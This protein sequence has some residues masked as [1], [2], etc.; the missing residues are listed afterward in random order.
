MIRLVA[1]QALSLSA[2]RS[3]WGPGRSGVHLARGMRFIQY[4]ATTSNDQADSPGISS[5]EVIF[6]YPNPPV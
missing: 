6:N 2:D 5:G 1:M 3:G 4:P